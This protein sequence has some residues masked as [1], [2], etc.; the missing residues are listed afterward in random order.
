[1]GQDFA[2]HFDGEQWHDLTHDDFDCAFFYDVAKDTS[3]K[4]WLVGKRSSDIDLPF[5][6]GYDGDSWEI[7]VKDD[8]GN[9]QCDW[10]G[11]CYHAFLHGI[12]AFDDGTMV[13]VGPAAMFFHDGDRWWQ[14]KEFENNNSWTSIENLDA[15]DVW[16]VSGQEFY[17]TSS[18]G[19]DRVSCQ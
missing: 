15:R 4:A 12:Q 14:I 9:P 7:A 8:S 1:M 10:N 16:G 2:A 18:W 5:I 3:G 13:A 11:S 17:V 6:A 19:I